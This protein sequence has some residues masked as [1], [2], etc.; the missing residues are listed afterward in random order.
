PLSLYARRANRADAESNLR[1]SRQVIESVLMAREI[2]VFHVGQE[3][4]NKV[5]ETVE[6][7]RV[8]GRKAMVA[9]AVLAP[10]YQNG[11]LLIAFAALATVALGGFSRVEV[12]GI[13]VLILL[14]MAS[15]T[16]GLQSVY[17]HVLGK[18]VYL[19]E[20]IHAEERHQQGALPQGTR[21]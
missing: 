8:R 3:V 21:R 18:A 7:T 16:Q 20:I 13:I 6:Q 2:E 9:Q 19:D 10:L 12:L 4:K 1:Y 5:G 14:R 11:V 17:H 15:Y